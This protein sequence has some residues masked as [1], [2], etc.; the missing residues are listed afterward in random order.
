MAIQAQT[1][2]DRVYGGDGIQ[3]GYG[4]QQTSDDGYILSGLSNLG[5]ANGTDMLLIKLG[6]FGEE[7]WSHTYGTLLWDVAFSVRELSQGGY[8]ICG[9]FSGLGTDSLTLI[10]TD[11]MG[12]VQWEHQYPGSLGR[13]IGYC[14]QETMDGGFVATGFSGTNVNTDIVLLKVDGNGLQQWRSTVDIGATDY[15]TSVT[16]LPDGGY[17][18]LAD[19]GELGTAGDVRLLRFDASGDT[20][21]TRTYG[22]AFHDHARGLCATDDGGYLITGGSDYPDRNI[23]LIRTDALGNE[24]WQRVHGDAMRDEFALDAQQLDDGGFVIGGR[25]E[26]A[27]T[28]DIEM[29]LFTTDQDGY[30]NWERTFQRGAFSEGNAIDRCSDGGFVILGS[31]TDTVGTL[32]ADMYLVKTDAMSA[33]G[34]D[35]VLNP[36]P[37]ITAFPNPANA[38]IQIRAEEPIKEVLL[39][40]GIGRVVLVR[41]F[42]PAFAT[43]LDTSGISV[44][45]YTMVVSDALGHRQTVRIV[46]VH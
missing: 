41:T 20:L 32:T 39:L 23:L 17:M 44:G 34:L 22:T 6:E 9:V 7:E 40:D 38:H 2:F 12:A 24:L 14:V 11:Q 29:L 5:D 3:L 25:K 42:N 21:W 27:G 18:V 1:T 33:V 37:R 28:N 19:E 26:N 31:T 30:I 35:V 10:R 16:V 43:D 15:G 8:I 45:T 46:I 13:S 36:T 4:V